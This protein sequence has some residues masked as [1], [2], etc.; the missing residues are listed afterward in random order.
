MHWTVGSVGATIC[1]FRRIEEDDELE[2]KGTNN[3]TTENKEE[4][5]RLTLELETNTKTTSKFFY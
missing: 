2:N 1:Y 4:E 3:G 5:Q